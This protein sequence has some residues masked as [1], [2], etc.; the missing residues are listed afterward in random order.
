ML[1]SP[2][3]IH[4]KRAVRTAAIPRLRSTSNSPGSA[5]VNLIMMRRP[6]TQGDLPASS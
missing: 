1:V 2:V 4:S 5:K 6:V 3:A